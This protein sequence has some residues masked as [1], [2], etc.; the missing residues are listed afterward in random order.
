MH[1]IGSRWTGSR[2]ASASGRPTA[3]DLAGDELPERVEVLERRLVRIVAVRGGVA[4]VAGGARDARHCKGNRTIRHRHRR[5]SGM[6]RRGW[7]G[8]RA[9]ARCWAR[10]MTIRNHP[11]Q[12]FANKPFRDHRQRPRQP[13]HTR[14]EAA[15]IMKFFWRERRPAQA[16]CFRLAASVYTARPE[17][18]DGAT[19]PVAM[20]RSV[21]QPGRALRSG[22]RGRRF[23]S[24]HSDHSFQ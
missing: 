6:W 12:A 23:E 14:P 18:P 13:D 7:I 21:A 16:A 8:V 4:Q 11:G 22:R 2:S 9:T 1:P 10:T 15:E 5:V 20:C 24:S 17:V 19:R 3:W